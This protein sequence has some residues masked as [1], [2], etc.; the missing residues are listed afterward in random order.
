[1]S[2]NILVTG[3]ILGKETELC[4]CNNVNFG[5]LYNHPTD[6]LWAD[7]IMLTYNEWDAI[8]KNEDSAIN[9]ATKMV[10]ER[11]QSEKM[12]ELIPDT[13]I[14]PGRAES[15]LQDVELDLQ[16][17]KDLYSASKNKHDPV[18]TMGNYHFCVPSLCTLY[19]AIELS[20]I[21]NA[22]FSL[23]QDELA[24][25]MALIPRKY[26]KEIH[27][28]RNT[29][30]DEVLSLLLPEVELGHAYLMDSISGKCSDCSNSNKC[31][32]TYLSQIE[33]QLDLILTLRQYDEVRLTCEVMD[34]ICERSML[35]G[36]VLTG[37]ELWDDLQ[38][39]AINT[40]KRI[41]SKLPKIR[42]WSKVS[43]YATIG[44]SAASFF[45]P[46]FAL[47]ATVPAVTNLALSS[48][49]EERKKETSWINFVN[50]PDSVLAQRPRIR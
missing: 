14:S 22:S 20:K 31:S 43:A 8:I 39:E 11:L 21:Y 16:L 24:Y 15:I 37:E 3:L 12:V 32:G 48:L 40:E 6:L 49:E 30:I 50:N 41:R 33:K 44:L 26:E 45:N 27:A 9:R 28:G 46:L 1:M 25:L 10:F 34:K 29:A 42:A 47:G 18:L 23:E 19:V 5:W 7:K 35:Q 13:V 38:E 36:H 4:L 17:I 2:K